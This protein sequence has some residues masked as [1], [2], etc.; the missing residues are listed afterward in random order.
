MR[1]RRRTH[2][3]VGLPRIMAEP[4]E[5]PGSKVARPRLQT[6]FRTSSIIKSLQRGKNMRRFYRLESLSH[7]VRALIRVRVATRLTGL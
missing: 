4:G 7:K 2:L 3:V 6:L 1:R 5:V